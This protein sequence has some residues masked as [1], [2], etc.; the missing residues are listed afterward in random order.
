LQPFHK[1]LPRSHF[2]HGD[3]NYTF[4]GYFFVP[5]GGVRVGVRA[6]ETKRLK[7]LE[8]HSKNPKEQK[9]KEVLKQVSSFS[10]YAD[11]VVQKVKSILRKKGINTFLEV[12]S[13]WE[14]Y[15]LQFSK[16]SLWCK[17]QGYVRKNTLKKSYTHPKNSKKSPTLER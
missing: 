16:L 15:L 6:Y 2:Y 3:K 1:L 5:Q 10:D 9:E 12:A 14:D 7:E 13:V 4:A 17:S 11:T 8:K